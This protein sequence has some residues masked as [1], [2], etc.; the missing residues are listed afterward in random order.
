LKNLDNTD[1]DDKGVY[2]IKTIKIMD[3]EK[4]KKERG[5]NYGRVDINFIRWKSELLKSLN[6]YHLYLL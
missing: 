4:E 3:D 5:L 6:P 1:K 2:S